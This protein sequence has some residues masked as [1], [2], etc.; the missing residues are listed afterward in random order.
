M[1]VVIKTEK[2]PEAIGPYSQAVK[3]NGFLFLSGQIPVNPAT[4][5]I[6]CVDII[7]Q[8]TAVMNNIQALLDAEGLELSDI[9]KTTIYLTDLADFARVN[10]AYGSFFAKDPPAR[11]T[12]QVQALPKGSK[13]EIEAIAVLK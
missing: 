12:V 7:S 5:F 8:T 9:V 13:I 1:K 2:A 6:E 4:G 11:S 10:E 3:A